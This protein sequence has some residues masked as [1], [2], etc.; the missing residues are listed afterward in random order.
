MTSD[1][2]RFTRIIWMDLLR[3]LSV[4]AVIVIHAA[5][6]GDVGFQPSSSDWQW[7]NL[8][9]S[10][11]RFAVPV[12]VMISGVMLLNPEKDYS[13]KNIIRYKIFHLGT[14]FVLWVIF[15]STVSQLQIHHTISWKRYLTTGPYHFW[16]LFMISGLY[17]ITPILRAINTK[18]MSYFL[19]LAVV[20]VFCLNTAA[21]FPQTSREA[22]FLRDRLDLRFAGGYIS[23]FIA[24]YWL[25][26]HRLDWRYRLCIYELGILSFLCTVAVR[27]LLSIRQ[28]APAGF[29]HDPFSINIFLISV[30]IFTFFQYGFCKITVSDKLHRLISILAKASFGVYLIH[31]FFLER[32]KFIGLPDFFIN[33]ALSIPITAIVTYT[34]CLISIGIISNIPVLRK[35]AM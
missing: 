1:G 5:A 11:V 30:A 15:Y 14:V 18:M 32:L 9:L 22:I 7:C 35:Y 34:L 17:L 21:Y 6:V 8:Y 2:Q 23:Y 12:L 13:I 27:G 29:L 10:C 31:I 4:F 3:I 28:G 33:P 19:I 16:F 24:G 25:A 26:N 20:F